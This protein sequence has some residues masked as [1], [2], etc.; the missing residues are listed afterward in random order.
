MPGTPSSPA[1]RTVRHNHLTQERRPEG[2][3][4]ACDVAWLRQQERLKDRPKKDKAM[5]ETENIYTALA[6]RKAS[7]DGDMDV[8][9]A[10]AP[11][12]RKRG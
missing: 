7:F 2:D 8:I 4:P 3:C 12:K 6:G 1:S 10:A 11:K 9:N 5:T